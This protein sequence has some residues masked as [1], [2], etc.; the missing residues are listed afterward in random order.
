MSSLCP[1]ASVYAVHAEDAVQRK[2]NVMLY[3]LWFWISTTAVESRHRFSTLSTHGRS[4][5][6]RVLVMVSSLY[7]ANEA[8]NPGR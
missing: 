1:G 4:F 8:G 7:G 6:F 5:L 3:E 2:S